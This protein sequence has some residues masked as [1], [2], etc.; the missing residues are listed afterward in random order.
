MILDMKYF[1]AFARM[2]FP[3]NWQTSTPFQ[4]G[5][6]HIHDTIPVRIGLFSKSIRQNPCSGGIYTGD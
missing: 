5:C 6:A 2:D 1:A 4:D 3:Y